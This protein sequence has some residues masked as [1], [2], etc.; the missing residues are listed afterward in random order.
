[1]YP[2]ELASWNFIVCDLPELVFDCRV[3]VQ[4]V[5]HSP[6]G[7]TSV[8]RLV[9]FASF[10]NETVATCSLVCCKT[11]SIDSNSTLPYNLPFS[12][13]IGPIKAVAVGLSLALSPLVPSNAMPH[14]H[15]TRG[16]VSTRLSLERCSAS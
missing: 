1:M 3:L 4:N 2:L 7:A 10:G 11:S 12:R 14:Y 15:H 16:G 9:N 13:D 8:R 6:P 5:P